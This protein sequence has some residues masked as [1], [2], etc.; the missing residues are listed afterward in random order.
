M[1]IITPNEPKRSPLDVSGLRLTGVDPAR[2]LRL[3]LV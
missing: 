3:I 2:I 1:D